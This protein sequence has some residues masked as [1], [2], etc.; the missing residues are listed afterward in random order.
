MTNKSKNCFFL[1]T[2]DRAIASKMVCIECAIKDMA[3]PLSLNF[4][5]PGTTSENTPCYVCNSA[6]NSKN[7]KE[8]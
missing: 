1:K 3:N 8:G 4:F 6:V 7:P 2:N 5:I